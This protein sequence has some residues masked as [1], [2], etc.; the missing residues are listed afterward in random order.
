MNLNAYWIQ[1]PKI[2]KSKLKVVADFICC[3]IP[4][5]PALSV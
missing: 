3:V 5:A 2:E 4:L 1:M